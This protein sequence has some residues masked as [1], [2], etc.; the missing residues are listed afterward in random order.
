MNHDEAK[1]ELETLFEAMEPDEFAQ[2]WRQYC[3]EIGEYGNIVYAMADLED[4]LKSSMYDG[5]FTLVDIINMVIGSSFSLEDRLFKY[6]GGKLNSFNNSPFDPR[7][8]AELADYI[9]DVDPY[10]V[11]SDAVDEIISEMGG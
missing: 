6:D 4:F 2:L 10:A 1:E 9:V 7:Y 8:F 11:E 3:E 5:G